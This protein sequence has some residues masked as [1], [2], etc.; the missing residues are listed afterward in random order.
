MQYWHEVLPGNYGLLERFNHGFPRAHC[1]DRPAG[2]IR[3]LEIGAGSGGHLA[4]EDLSFQEYTALE[5]R[6]AMAAHI[7]AKYPQV[8]VLVGDVQTHIPA[9]DA[10]FDRVVIVHVLEHLPNLPAALAEIRRVLKPGGRCSVVLPCEGG[11]L[12][13]LAR[14][15]SSKRTFEK[16]YRSSYDW[17]IRAEHVNNCVEIMEEL[18]QLFQVTQSRFWPFRIPNVHMNLV[19]GVHL[20]MS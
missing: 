3:T 9:L 8:K 4:Y 10:Y 1:S 18:R 14:R 5:L 16:R 19:V 11:L 2:T 20:R 6:E 7:R 12:Y 17:C 15:A 13:D